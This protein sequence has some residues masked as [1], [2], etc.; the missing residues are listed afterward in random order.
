MPALLWQT[1]IH[2]GLFRLDGLIG[3]IGQDGEAGPLPE[4]FAILWLVVLV[5]LA[6]ID[7]AGPPISRGRRLSLL[8]TIVLF[9]LVGRSAS[10]SPGAP[11]AR[12]PSTASTAA[13]T[14]PR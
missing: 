5:A 4:W 12:P 13:T 3:T 1:S 8:G 2:E 7:G 11:S 9:G 14:R 6:M 10:T